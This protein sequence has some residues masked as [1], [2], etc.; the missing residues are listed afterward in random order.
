MS[1]TIDALNCSANS[2]I[3]IIDANVRRRTSSVLYSSQTLLILFLLEGVS[4]DTELAM[5]LSYYRD[6]VLCDLA[7]H[8]ALQSTRS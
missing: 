6:I 1:Y 5:S 7:S 4:R 2:S 3:N 8:A